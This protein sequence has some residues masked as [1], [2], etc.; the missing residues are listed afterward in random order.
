MNKIVL[1]FPS[2]NNLTELKYYFII[3]NIYYVKLF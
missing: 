1:L 2:D 3:I